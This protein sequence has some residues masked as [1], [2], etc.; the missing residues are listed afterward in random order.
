MQRK[1]T[2]TKN[3]SKCEENYTVKHNCHRTGGKCTLVVCDV[4]CWGT[5]YY[6]QLELQDKIYM[7]APQGGARVT[8]GVPIDFSW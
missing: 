5:I 3:T 8:L 2:R 1:N 4:K 6:F 7:D